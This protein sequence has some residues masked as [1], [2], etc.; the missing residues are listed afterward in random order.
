MVGNLI[1]ESVYGTHCARDEQR[2]G[3]RKVAVHRLTGDAEPARDVGNAW[4]AAWT[5]YAPF[6]FD[7]EREDRWLRLAFRPHGLLGD[8]DGAAA[9]RFREIAPIVFDAR[10]PSP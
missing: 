10:E 1:D 6:Q 4:K 9:R 3:I 7:G 5:A 2:I 8:F